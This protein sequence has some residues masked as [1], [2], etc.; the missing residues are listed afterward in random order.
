[1]AQ[2]PN[3]FEELEKL[4]DRLSRQLRSPRR[5]GDEGGDADGEDLGMSVGSRGTGVDVTDANGEFV[6]VVDAP[7]F[8]RDD[9][10]LT[11]TNRRLK[12][13]GEREQTVDDAD[14]TYLRR[15]RRTHSFSRQITLP[16]PVDA[17]GV[18]AHLNN[19]VVTIRLPKRDYDDA[20]HSIDI[21]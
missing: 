15:E 5:S 19:G 12:I 13:D 8:E 17:D 14:D 16:G 18:E 4:I 10:E 7:G 21:E 2:R 11:L 9:I 6:V 20:A 1:M 3:P